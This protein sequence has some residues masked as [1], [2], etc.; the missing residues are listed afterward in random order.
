MSWMA[1]QV[2]GTQL[3]GASGVE[4]MHVLSTGH[5]LHRYTREKA[6]TN[7]RKTN[8]SKMITPLPYRYYAHQ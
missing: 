5:F 8:V 7:L 4:D 3:S 2:K 1:A 6:F